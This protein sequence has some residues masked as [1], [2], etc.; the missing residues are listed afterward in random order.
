MLTKI[1][2]KE[3]EPN[4][5]HTKAMQYSLKRWAELTVFTRVAGATLSNAAAE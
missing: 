5:P 4:C 1:E 3:V 2:K